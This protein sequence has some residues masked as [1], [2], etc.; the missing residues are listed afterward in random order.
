MCTCLYAHLHMHTSVHTPVHEYLRLPAHLSTCVCACLPTCLHTTAARMSVAQ[1]LLQ[2]VV[3]ISIANDM[4]RR[5]T[6]CAQVCR[7]RSVYTSIHMPA[8]A[9]CPPVISY[10]ILVM[11]YQLWRIS[12]GILVIYTHACKRLVSSGHHTG[13]HTTMHTTMHSYAHVST[14]MP[15]HGSI[16]ACPHTFDTRE[17]SALIYIDA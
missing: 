10:G 15:A 9:W 7:N 12:Y 3:H 14:H 4:C 8:K 6:V 2:A 5:F 17:H 1:N 16:L 13:L 11:A